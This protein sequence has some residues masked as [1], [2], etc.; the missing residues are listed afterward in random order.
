M[1]RRRPEQY[2]RQ[3]RR[4][5]KRPYPGISP[6]VRRRGVSGGGSGE[7]GNDDPAM[8]RGEVGSPHSSIEAGE[9]RRSEG[10]DGMS[11]SDP[12]QMAFVFADSRPGGAPGGGGAGM[13]PG[14]SRHRRALLLRARARTTARSDTG[15]SGG[16]GLLEE[17]AHDANLASGLLAVVR[18]AGAPGVDGHTTARAEAAAA[19]L[20][21]RLSRAL[22]T[23]RYRP[24]PVRRVM[25]P[26]T[27]GGERGLGVPTVEDRAVQQAVLRVLQPRFE[28]RFHPSSHGFRPGRGLPTAIAEATEHLSAGYQVVVDID[29]SKFFDRV[30]HQRLLAALGREIEDPRVLRLIGAMLGVGAVLADGTCVTTREGTPQGGPLSPLLSNVVLNELDWELA[31]RGH[32]FVRYA[33]DFLVFVR[34]RRAAERVMAS[35]ERLIE[36]RLRLKVNRAKSRITEVTEL[37]FLGFRFEP[38][39][40]PARPIAVRPDKAALKRVS[41]RIRELTPGN[42]GSAFRVCLERLN[43]YLDGWAAHARLC[44]KEALWDFRRLDAHIRRRV[45]AI[46]VRQKK[47]RRYLRRHLLARGVGWRAATNAAYKCRG[48]WRASHHPGLER[49]YPN[50]WFAERLTSLAQRWHDL[51]PPPVIPAQLKLQWAG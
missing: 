29:L 23:G 39:G 37:T 34:S 28:P 50:A 25:I 6:G 10:G 18:K 22:V 19:R 43:R 35:L 31:R 46:L 1:T 45:R 36:G 21:P 42:W 27:G 14:V 48:P 49:A 26:K 3:A 2:G 41:R 4:D 51:N 20:V 24:Q 13:V 8:P 17:V 40:D 33:D 9:S 16:P 5:I 11:S 44:S 38:S 15:G 30:D 12:C 47:R 7:G 32:R